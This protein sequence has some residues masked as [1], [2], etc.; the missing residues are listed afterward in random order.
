MPTPRYKPLSAMD[1]SFLLMEDGNV[2]QHGMG[3]SIFELGPLKK[4]AGGIDFDLVKRFVASV[5]HLLPRYRQKLAWVPIQNRPVWI[6]DPDF[7]LDYHIRHTALPRPGHDG[8]LKQL[9]ARIGAIQLDRA[10]PLWEMWVVEGLQ[11]DRFALISK[12]HHCMVD[13]VSGLDISQVLLSRTPDYEMREAPRYVPH[14]APSG[15]DL[16]RAAVVD[17]AR[18]PVH[19]VRGLQHFR[20]TT[21]NVRDELL[22]RARAFGELFTSSAQPAEATPLNGPLGPHRRYDWLDL[23]L[24]HVRAISKVFNC[25]VNDVILATVTGAVRDFLI[26]HRVHPEDLDLRAAVPVST[27]GDAERGELGNRVSSWLVHLPVGEASVR[28]RVETIR[29]ATEELKA[30]RQVLAVEMMMGIAEWTPSVLLALGMRAAGGAANIY[31]TNMPGPQFPLYL[32]GAKLLKMYPQAPLLQNLGLCVAI[33]SYN[34]NMFWGFH[35]DY[36]LVPDL[37]QFV[38]MIDTSFRALAGAAGVNLDRPATEVRA[39]RADSGAGR[40]TPKLGRAVPRK[41]SLRAKQRKSAV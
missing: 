7:N 35:A 22:V 34:G 21:D 38:D 20:R 2:H 5:L 4:P 31:V 30:S 28:R 8:Q 10:R 16:L 25:T 27:R 12:T 39:L 29:K 15:W 32:L 3:T 9:A 1:T 26:A 19:V 23:S 6:D 41:A 40:P 14:A 24:G 11:D 36:E 33:I 13:G 37:R 18:L 17:R